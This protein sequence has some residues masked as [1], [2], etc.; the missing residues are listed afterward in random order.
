MREQLLKELTFSTSRSSGPGGQH[1]NKTESRVTLIWNLENSTALSADEKALLWK[2][3]RSKLTV[4][5]DLLMSSQSGRSQLRNKEDVIER[6]LSLIEKLSKP[7]KKR[8]KTKPS[9]A[10]V[11]RRLKAK[12]ARGERKKKRGKPGDE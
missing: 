4:E 11:E 8:V 5:G 6:F 10:S 3:L 7:P 12:K 2:R 9:K 1:V